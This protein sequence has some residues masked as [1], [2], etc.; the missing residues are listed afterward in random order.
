MRIARV[1][2]AGPLLL[3]A[4]GAEEP[5]GKLEIV[6]PAAAPSGGRIESTLQISLATENVIGWSV[7]VACEGLL[8]LEAS[9]AGTDFDRFSR[10]GHA[11]SGHPFSE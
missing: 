8:A 6:A 3:A 7:A 5:V 9:A 4:A 11:E 1:W 2:V 10:G